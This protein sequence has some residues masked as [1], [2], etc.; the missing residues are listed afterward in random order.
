MQTRIFRAV[1]TAAALL[2][3]TLPAHAQSVL[4]R[5]SPEAGMVTRYVMDME[6]YMDAP[7]MS[8][9][10]PMMVG[11]HYQTQTIRSVEGDVF[12][13]ATV[14]DSADISTPGMPMLQ[15]QMPDL[16]G[17]TQVVKMDARG[18]VVELTNVGEMDPQAQ[19][20]MTQMGGNGFGMELPEG[21]VSPGDSWTATLDM[22]TP[23]APGMDMSM[24]MEVT[25]TLQ[26]VEGDVATIAF[27]GPITISGGGQGMAMD[28]TGGMSGTIV[29]DLGMGRIESSDTELTFDM[30]AQ[31]MTM[32]QD[33]TIGMRRLP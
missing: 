18:R 22:N 10:Q 27:E 4:L 5:I 20:M 25:Y 17:Q 7:M 28:G 12:E 23:A 19:Q 14:T 32:S 24:V 15:N 31:G 2:A 8:S 11:Q 6:M 3:L 26:A 1:A 30:N 9:D 33:M 16:A 29:L 13:V 21:E